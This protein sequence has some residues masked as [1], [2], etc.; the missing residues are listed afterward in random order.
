M[1]Q[2]ASGPAL[3]RSRRKQ[4]LLLASQL[5]RGQA[6]VAFDEIADR[7]DLVV[8]RVVRV[9]M[10]LSSPLVWAA[11]SAVGGLMLAVTLRRARAVN[12]LRWG[13]LAWRLWRSAGPVLAHYR[14]AG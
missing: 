7:A 4:D 12:V 11:G 5:A 9:R 2:R 13:W 1:M 3:Q 6:V 8:Y 14:A 10:W